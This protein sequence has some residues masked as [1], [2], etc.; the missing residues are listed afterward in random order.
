MS[1]QRG[2][3]AFAGTVLVAACSSSEVHEAPAPLEDLPDASY[4]D[5]GVDVPVPDRAPECEECRIYPDDCEPEAFCPV[6]A[7]LET[8]ARL[9]AIAGSSP[10]A[11]WVAGSMGAVLSFDGQSWARD[12][13]FENGTFGALLLRGADEI[14]L[15]GTLTTS[16]VRSSALPSDAG[17][18]GWTPV[19]AGADGVAGIQAMWAAPD[20]TWVW[21]GLSN[22]SI[23]RVPTLSR[24]R[25]EGATL[26]RGGAAPVPG[27]IILAMNGLDGLSKDEVWAVG[28]RG[29]AYRITGADGTTPVVQ[30]F[31]T[32]TE[33][34]L[35][36]VALASENDIWAVGNVGT[37]R[38]Y[39]GT[40]ATW[41]RVDVPTIQ[42]LRA[43]KAA[44][45][46]DVWAVGDGATVLHFDG[47]EWARVPIGGLGGARP[48][49]RAVLPFGHDRALVVGDRIILELRAKEGR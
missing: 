15:G 38:R 47:A 5:A 8:S 18:S 29:T 17:A 6:A 39:R 45:P 30:A 9:L 19:S 31:N 26:V 49:L 34:A 23:Y 46:V 35:N 25:R 40:D 16:Y 13:S 14:W 37:V 7:P 42:S 48:N 2:R 12:P 24:V 21:I 1:Q 4:A 22:T 32:Q 33:N 11:V 10:H 36:A 43:V 28:E 44:S 27:P 41:E 3:W 20:G